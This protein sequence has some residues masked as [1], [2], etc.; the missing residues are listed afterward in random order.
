MTDKSLFFVSHFFYTFLLSVWELTIRW[1]GIICILACKIYFETIRNNKK[2]RMKR[3]INSLIG[4]S[5]QATDGKIGEIKDFYFDDETWTI[6][7]LIVKTGSWLSGRKVLISTVALKKSSELNELVPV[8]LTK[9][10]IQNS[11]DIDTDKPVSRQ[12]EAMLN[13]HHFWGNYWGSGYYGG[14][15]GIGNASPVRIKA[16]DRDPAEDI[17]LRSIVQVNG[18]TIHASDGEIGHVSDFILD[19]ETWQL[20]DIIVDTH[21]WIGGKKVLIAVSHI[22]SISFLN[23]LVYLHMPIAAIKDSELFKKDKYRQH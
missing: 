8:N 5:I 11:P 15:M 19:D 4:Y 9:E 3:N 21:D 20:S 12:K 7:Y 18:Y 13:Q 1:R 2:I 6:R 14:E 17:H 10:Q 23:W 16:I 22:H